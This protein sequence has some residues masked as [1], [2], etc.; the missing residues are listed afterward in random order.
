MLFMDLPHPFSIVPKRFWKFLLLVFLQSNEKYLI[1]RYYPIQV[2]GHCFCVTEAL[3]CK[4]IEFK[5][6]KFPSVKLEWL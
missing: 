2:V 4:Y 6:K 5:Q 3:S 1:N